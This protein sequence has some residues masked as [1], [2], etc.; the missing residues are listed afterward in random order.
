[1][2]RIP[3][4]K[5]VPQE[6]FE[7]YFNTSRSYREL[8]R[9][10]GYSQDGGGTMKALH[11]AVKFYGLNDEH[12]LGQ[13]WNK[14]NY[15]WDS[16]TFSSYKKNGKSI[17]APLI[18]LRGHRCEECGNTEWLGQPIKL[19]V[20]HID[21]DRSNNTLDNLKLLCPNCHSYTETFC[22]KSKVA[23]VS[24]ET[25]VEAL[26]TSNTIHQALGILGLSQCGGNYT[27]AYRLI[28]E[29][30]IQHLQNKST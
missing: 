10:L 24:D 15:D 1:M 7:E 21:G 11:E 22:Y 29:Y 25:F 18:H 20:H 23:T 17:A 16:F 4:W 3:K 2:P 12:F 9:K 19:E 26:Q 27:R 30:D 5:Q 8:A 6:T 28:D 14:N 13:G